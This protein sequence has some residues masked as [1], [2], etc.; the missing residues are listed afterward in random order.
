M[1]VLAETHVLEKENTTPFDFGADPQI[2]RTL[3]EG[4]RLTPYSLPRS[5]DYTPLPKVREHTSETLV[6]AAILQPD[7]IQNLNDQLGDLVKAAVGL[8]LQFQLR[9]E[10]G[11]T[12]RLSPKMVDKVNVL[13][14]EVS[15]KLVLRE[16]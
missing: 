8:N 13:L 15:E 12:A 3:V 9:V 10:L 5:P 16:L 11:P 14:S 4:E 2:V 6:A 7:E 1:D